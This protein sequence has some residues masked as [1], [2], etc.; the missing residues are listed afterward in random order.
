MDSLNLCIFPNTL[1]IQYQ[2]KNNMPISQLLQWEKKHRTF[3]KA[4]TDYDNT[5]RCVFPNH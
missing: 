5:T 4:T 1:K 3:N 2:N